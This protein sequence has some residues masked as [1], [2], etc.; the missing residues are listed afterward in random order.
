MFCSVW[1]HRF[2]LVFAVCVF[3][4]VFFHC[5]PYMSQIQTKFVVTL[6]AETAAKMLLTYKRCRNPTS[7]E[8]LAPDQCLSLGGGQTWPECN[9]AKLIHNLVQPNNRLN[10]LLLFCIL[11]FSLSFRSSS[12][13]GCYVKMTYFI[14]IS[15]FVLGWILL[16]KRLF[17]PQYHLSRFISFFIPHKLIIKYN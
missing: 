7:V 5:W 3:V 4:C 17:W 13:S 8:P 15:V 9:W 6:L 14:L 11:C 1:D 10:N 12:G 16:W 2:F